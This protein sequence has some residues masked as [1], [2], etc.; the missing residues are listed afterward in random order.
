MKKILLASFFLAQ[1]ATIFFV[2]FTD[3]KYF[4]WVPYDQ[5]STFQ[6][7]VKIDGRELTSDE[8][9]ERYLFT[10]P[11]QENRNIA[12]VFSRI[13]QYEQSYGRA[14]DAQVSVKFSINGKTQ[15]EWNYPN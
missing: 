2:S 3:E 13:T 1:V 6:I 5:I 7:A 12:H 14:D 11:G 9:F 4:G 10:N 15:Q 8:V